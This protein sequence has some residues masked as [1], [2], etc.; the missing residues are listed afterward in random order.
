MAPRQ[1]KRQ[2]LRSQSRIRQL[3]R[4]IPVPESTTSDIPL[5]A[6]TTGSGVENPRGDEGYSTSL[7]GN[8]AIRAILERDPDRPFL[9]YVAFN[10][11]HTP[12]Q[13]PP[14]Y[15]AKYA[16][17]EKESRRVFAAMV[18]CMDSA[19]G[20]ILGTIESE[21]LAQETLVVFI[22]DNGGLLATDGGSDNRAA[23]G[24][25]DSDLGGAGFGPRQ[26]FTGRAWSRAGE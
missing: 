8:E 22:S 13:A 25:K 14:E 12:L 4:P 1:C 15:I 23:Q 5:L 2:V 10:A 21:G 6:R 3:L 19:I 26:Q 20:R 24:R 17:I 7:I 11:P 9:L 16:H 18:D